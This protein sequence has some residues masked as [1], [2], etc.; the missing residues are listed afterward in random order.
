[1]KRRIANIPILTWLGIIGL[2]YSAVTL[3]YYTY[4]YNF[5]VGAGTLAANFY[6][7]FLEVVG[8]IFVGCIVWFYAMSWF[9]SRG[10][11]PS[12]KALQEIPP[13]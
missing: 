4:D 2:I 1:M 5:Y 11:V 7:I 8:T 9:R 12:K 10:G 13:E 6:F 3:G